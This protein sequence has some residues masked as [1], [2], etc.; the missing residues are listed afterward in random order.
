MEVDNVK[1]KPR[2]IDIASVE[3]S[4]DLLNLT[5]ILAKNTHEIWSEIR[6]KNGWSYG[7]TRDDS[8]KQSP[9]LISYEDLPESEKDYDRAIS[10]NIMKVI[11]KLGYEIQKVK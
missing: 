3:L 6:L 9:Y 11:K 2:P 4:D 10:I 8:I 7:E 1:Y 5:E